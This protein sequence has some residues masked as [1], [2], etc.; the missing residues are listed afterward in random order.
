[1]DTELPVL[2]HVRQAHDQVLATLRRKH[3]QHG[4]IVHAF[5][6]SLQQAQQFIK[7]GFGIGVCG[8]ITYDRARKIR[9]NCAQLPA[10]WLVLETDAPDIIV[11]ERREMDMNLPEYLPFVLHA[12]ADLR[13]EAV[14]M[15]ANYTT[16]NAERLL[17]LK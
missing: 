14:E 3:F 16:E 13:E 9:R 15:T 10:E 11:A 5:S 1:M 2:L 4:G 8:T 17:R 12:L 6:G 7:L